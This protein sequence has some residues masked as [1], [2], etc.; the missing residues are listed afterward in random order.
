MMLTSQNRFTPELIMGTFLE[1]SQLALLS[2]YNIPQVVLGKGNNLIFS[3]NV[4]SLN[5]QM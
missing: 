3:T 1:N 4:F 2:I 5:E